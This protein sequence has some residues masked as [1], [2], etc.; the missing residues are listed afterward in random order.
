MPLKTFLFIGSHAVT[1]TADD[2]KRR[3]SDSRELAISHGRVDFRAGKRM[4]QNPYPAGSVNAV[5]WECGWNEAFTDSQQKDNLSQHQ[6]GVLEFK[7][8]G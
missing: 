6:A 5:N 7:K 8:V 4:S 2:W 1:W 3:W